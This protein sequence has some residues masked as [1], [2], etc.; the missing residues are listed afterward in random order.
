MHAAQPH[1]APRAANHRPLSPL[2]HLARMLETRADQPAVIWRDR[3][4]DWRGFGAM[5]ARLA[6]RLR[7]AGIGQ[8]DVVSVLL[9][10]RPEMLAAHFAV[11][12][13]GA[14]LN[15][16]NTRLDAGVI[17]HILAHSGSALLLAE[18]DTLETARLAAAEG[19]LVVLLA[20][21]GPV[22]EGAW[23]ITGSDEDP[24]LPDDI[25]CN[26]ADEWQPICLNYTS[27][28]TGLPK[29][30]VYHH[31]GAA[32]NALGNVLTMGFGAGSVYLWTLPMFHC[33][34]WCHPWAVTAAGGVHVCLDKPEPGA[35]FAAI[36]DHG[37]THMACA[38]VV[39][40]ML[41]NHP[42][43]S[44]RG[45]APGR[46]TVGSGGAAPSVAL[47]SG[48]DALGFDFYHLYGLT[49]SFGPASACIASAGSTPEER[50]ARLA[51]QG[52]RHPTASLLSVLDAEGQPVPQDGETTGEITLR[53][54]TLMAGYWRD[55]EATERAF[56]G[57]AFHTGDLAVRHPGGEIEIRD[58]AR[59]IIISGGE[60]IS[61][62]EVENAL[63]RHPAVLLAAI[64]AAPDPKWGEVPCAFIELKE[65]A[66]VTGAELSAFA[67]SHLAGYKLPRRYVFGPLPRTAT[68]KIQKYILRERLRQGGEAHAD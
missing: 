60:N 58:R 43:R 8:G 32:L 9:V 44:L 41:L 50:A 57:G 68:G 55:P 61:S 24:G 59:D 26:V 13:L 21:P 5:V 53:G 2:E 33:N 25:L 45:G 22:P 17:A 40:Y 49:E 4:W 23:P 64:V 52:A 63:H 39:L 19:P 31:R 14:V 67:R 66:A 20:D 3:R 29:G 15:S 11:P 38:P 51:R 27:G 12:M 62:L 36:R 65:G 6:A 47:I 10:N 7:E 30:A 56:A 28:T 46:V 35:I 18:P 1:L 16:I 48:M 34:G 54:N 42:D 37:V